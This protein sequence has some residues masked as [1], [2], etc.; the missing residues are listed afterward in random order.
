[1]SADGADAD[2]E[3]ISGDEAEVNES[4]PAAQAAAL[5]HQMSTF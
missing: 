5:D 1:M 3:H 4:S 2:G